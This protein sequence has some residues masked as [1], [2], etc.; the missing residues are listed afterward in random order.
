[1]IGNEFRIGQ[2]WTEENEQVAL[3]ALKIFNIFVSHNSIDGIGL[4]LWC[5]LIDL[6][7]GVSRTGESCLV[8]LRQ[9]LKIFRCQSSLNH[10][11]M[12]SKTE[13]P[14]FDGKVS[15]TNPVYLEMT[16]SSNP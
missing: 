2:K 12:N 16:T 5:L 6:S 10:K 4:F 7:L 13:Y 8:I 9:V 15:L 1:M 14:E 3:V 11:T